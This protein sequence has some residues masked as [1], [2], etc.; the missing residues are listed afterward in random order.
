[1]ILSPNSNV[2]SSSKLNGLDLTR[3]HS[4]PTQ[5]L[6]LE[7]VTAETW[8]NYNFHKWLGLTFQALL[9]VGSLR[10][11]EA[12]LIIAMPCSAG[13][14]VWLGPGPRPWCWTH[15]WKCPRRAKNTKR[16]TVGRLCSTDIL[17]QL[18]KW[19]VHSQIC[20]NENVKQR[21]VDKT[22]E[23]FLMIIHLTLSAVAILAFPATHDVSS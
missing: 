3:F 11:I 5:S 12:T 10:L 2:P 17:T 7:P 20:E 23:L 13:H 18:Q 21:Y 6:P 16:R 1:M 4:P 8:T 22:T 9:R 19:H 14:T 15:D